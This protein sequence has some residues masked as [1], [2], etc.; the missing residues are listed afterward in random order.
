MKQASTGAWRCWHSWT[1]VVYVLARTR[2]Q[3]AGQQEEEFRSGRITLRRSHVCRMG[4]VHHE[5]P[6]PAG[7]HLGMD[8]HWV[9]T[10]HMAW[11][12]GHTL[13][14]SHRTEG[15]PPDRLDARNAGTRT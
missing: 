1:T 8:M 2:R 12:D 6:A 13:I 4:P 14:Q 15:R 11:T 5:A 9:A 7:R 3:T 10:R